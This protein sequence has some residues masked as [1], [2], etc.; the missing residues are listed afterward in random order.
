MRSG[1]GAFQLAPNPRMDTPA[2][3]LANDFIEHAP[4][5]PALYSPGAIGARAYKINDDATSD[6]GDH[7]DG[8]KGAAV[9]ASREA[10]SGR[11][12][13]SFQITT[14]VNSS[15]PSMRC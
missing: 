5:L 14:T 10:V 13:P 3:R 7:G 2:N 6:I 4:A 11:P 1:S 15:G 9:H 12:P 8:R